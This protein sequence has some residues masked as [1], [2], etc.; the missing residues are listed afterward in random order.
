VL[1]LP[2]FEKIFEEKCDG[3]DV[4][5]GGALAQEGHPIAY[6]SEKLYDSKRKYSTYNKKFY[7]IIR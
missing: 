1:A 6:F 7:D 2:C 3:S 5:I 4:G